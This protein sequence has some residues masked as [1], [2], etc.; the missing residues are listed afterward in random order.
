MFPDYPY[1]D[2]HQ[3][4][5]D[6][7]VENV[8]TIIER[9]NDGSLKGEDGISP[10][11]TITDIPGGHRVTITDADH[12]QGQSFDVMDGEGGGGGTSN[13]NSLT[14][15]PK[16]N[17]VEIIGNKTASDYGLYVKPQTGIPKT[18]LAAAVQESLNKADTALQQHQ[19]LAAYRTAA[20]QD[21]LDATKITAPSSPATGAFLVWNGTA[22]VAQTLSTWQGGSY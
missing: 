21:V 5:L 18:D 11:I 4:N 2:A 8:T 13:Y 3:L 17:N 22:W 15:K 6:W 7:M 9:L 16:I 12:P 14:N 19:S 10:T 1:T 20:A